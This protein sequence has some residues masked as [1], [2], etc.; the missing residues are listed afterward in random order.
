MTTILLFAVLAA[1]AEAITRLLEW[2]PIR[3]GTRQT[4]D[5][6]RR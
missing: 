5:R 6:G 2:A 4:H 3:I 1:I